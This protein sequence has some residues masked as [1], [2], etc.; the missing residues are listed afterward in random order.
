MRVLF[1]TPQLPHPVVS[2]GVIKSR[3]LIE[4]FADRHEVHVCSLLKGRDADHVDDF[5][6]RVPLAGFHSTPV[7]SARS[8]INLLRSFVAGVP[9]SVF[10]NRCAQMRDHIAKIIA[11]F[12]VVFVD[13]FLMFQ[14]VPASY[15]GRIV[16]HQHNAEY[17]MWERYAQVHASV[18]YRMAAQSESR[19]IRAYERAIGLRAS[20]VLAAPNDVEALAAIGVPRERFV[21]TLHLGDEALLARPDV[22]FEDTQPRLLY[23]GSLDWEAN[24]DGLLWFL[25]EVWP[26]LLERRGDLQLVV[27]GR[28]PGEELTAEAARTRGVQL[29]GFVEDLESLYATS[30]VFIAPL[31]F[32]SGIKVKVINALY[33]G[34]P[35]VTTDVGVE[36]LAAVSGRDLLISDDASAMSGGILELLDDSLRWS[37]MRDA[38]RDL[39][40]REYGWEPSL[41]RAEAA[42]HD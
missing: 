13:H 8:A 3:K 36:G 2:G 14:Y 17:V 26:T 12:D 31:R 20:R 24:R 15:G 21:E 23:V 29:L 41:R 40:R 27:A 10:R 5:R 39:A 18:P 32:G 38:G 19:R 42:L 37:V 4:H 22:E 6:S 30:R 16:L 9:L 28:N 35:V 34:L 33:R 11:S 7:D 1:L 25:R